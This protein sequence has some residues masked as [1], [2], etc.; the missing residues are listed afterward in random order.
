M[1]SGESPDITESSGR[2]LKNGLTRET[3]EILVR[4]GYNLYRNLIIQIL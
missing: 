2:I 4:Q 3:V 1:C